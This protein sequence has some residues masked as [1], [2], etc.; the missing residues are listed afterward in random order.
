MG[1]T[2]VLQNQSGALLDEAVADTTDL[3]PFVLPQTEDEVFH[4]IPYIDRYG[5]TVFN[6]L[7]MTPLLREFS[8]LQSN[9]TDPDERYL[10]ERISQLAV[11]CMNTDLSYLR[12]IGD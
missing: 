2:I 11:R 6:R 3:L 5:D 1:L 7:Q 12:F 10:L 9:T 8:V 4:Y